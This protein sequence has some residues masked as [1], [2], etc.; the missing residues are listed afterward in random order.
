MAYH[1]TG[2]RDHGEEHGLTP[3]DAVQRYGTAGD[4]AATAMWLCHRLGV[5]PTRLGWQG[6]A[7][8]AN[9]QTGT[10]ADNGA[11]VTDRHLAKMNA[12]YAVVKVGGKTRV[13][14]MEDNITYPGCKVPVYSSIADFCAFHTYPKKPYITEAGRER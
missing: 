6:R 5:E 1:P 14:S 4:A 11:R 3:I 2:I 12:D 9:E 7:N 8:E 13:V 10:G